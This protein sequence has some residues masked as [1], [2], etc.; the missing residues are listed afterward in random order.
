MR[1]IGILYFPGSK[2]APFGKSRRGGGVLTIVKLVV[3]GGL[4]EKVLGG[5]VPRINEERKEKRCVS[6]RFTRT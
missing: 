4:F 3:L 6:D 2:S 1:H 5:W